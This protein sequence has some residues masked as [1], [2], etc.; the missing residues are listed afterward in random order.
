MKQGS[1]NNNKNSAYKM[2]AFQDQGRGQPRSGVPDRL[3]TN[4]VSPGIT[5]VYYLE[6][7]SGFGSGKEDGDRIQYTA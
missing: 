2:A 5:P 4:E 1:N 7:I 3:G 6:D